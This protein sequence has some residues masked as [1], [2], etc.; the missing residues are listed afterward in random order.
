MQI[1]EH[2][3]LNEKF[4]VKMIVDQLEKGDEVITRLK[5]IEA[6]RFEL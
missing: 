1:M 2:L 6:Q 5:P 4:T 3:Y